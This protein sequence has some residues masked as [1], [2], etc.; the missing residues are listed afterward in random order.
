MSISPPLRFDWTRYWV[1]RGES[2][3]LNRGYLLPKKGVG[4]WDVVN[5]TEKVSTLAELENIPCL[6][7]LGDLGLGKSVEIL[8]E[9]ERLMA[10]CHQGRRQVLRVDLKRRS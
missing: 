3:K 5:H 2:P 10:H 6:V 9:E 4:G 1:P 8:R 7:L